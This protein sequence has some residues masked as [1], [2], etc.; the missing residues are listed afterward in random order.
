MFEVAM[1][2]DE[3]QGRVGADF[4]DGVNIVA[5]KQNAKVNKL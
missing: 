4:R 3:F 2:L 1:F 5:S